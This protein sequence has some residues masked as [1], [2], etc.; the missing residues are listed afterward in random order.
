MFWLETCY[1]P[2]P[3]S[4]KTFLTRT[5]PLLLC[6]AAGTALS[7]VSIYAFW[8]AIWTFHSVPVARICD[9]LGG[10]V[11]FPAKWVFEF[12]GGDQ[13]TIFFDPVAFSGTNGLILGVLLYCAFRAVLRRWEAGK[14]V[15]EGPALPRRVEAKVS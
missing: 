1:S 2:T 5:L 10:I 14:G 7:W 15:E 11:L 3:R 13:S 6:I 12:L 9:A 4:V 8:F